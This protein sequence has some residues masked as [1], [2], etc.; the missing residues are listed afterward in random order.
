MVAG[1]ALVLWA[2]IALARMIYRATMTPPAQPAPVEE[3][4]VKEPQVEEA[5]SGPRKP[6]SIPPLYID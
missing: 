3:V 4:Q 1:A 5:P 6:Q 2:L